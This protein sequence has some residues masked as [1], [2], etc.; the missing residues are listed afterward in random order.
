MLAGSGVHAPSR[1][2]A[3]PPLAFS[4]E[5]H[6]DVAATIANLPASVRAGVT[7]FDFPLLFVE[8]TPRAFEELLDALAGIERSIDRYS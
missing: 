5:G 3:A 8:K 6:L 7:E 1:I 4:A 2:R